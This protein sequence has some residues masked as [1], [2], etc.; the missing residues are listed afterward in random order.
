MIK[1]E[2]EKVQE[3]VFAYGDAIDEKN[4]A[5]LAACFTED[6]VFDYGDAVSNGGAEVAEYIAAAVENLEGTQHFF[7]N[8]TVDI[9]GDR[10]HFT[11]NSLG[12]HWR[13]G[14]HGGDKWLASGRYKVEVR[15]VGGDWKISH[16]QVRQ[17]WSEG[18][19]AIFHPAD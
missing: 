19:A 11:C 8:F 3:L 2:R 17:V 14:P 4:F 10:G 18:D 16:A 13:G 1:T 7:T 12:Q 6:A 5:A 9:D 15:R